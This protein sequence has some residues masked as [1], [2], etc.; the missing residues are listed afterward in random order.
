MTD[1]PK[2]GFLQRLA[3]LAIDYVILQIAGEAITYPL[4]KKFGMKTD[5]VLDQILSGAIDLK[6]IMVFLLV[7]T[8]LLTILWGFYFTYFVGSTGQTL[9]KK[10]LGIRVIRADEKPMDYKTAFNRFI[11]Y[12]VSASVLFLGFAWALFDANKQAWHDK[13]AHTY[14]VKQTTTL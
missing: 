9:G 12:T 10:A 5:E 11:G 8:T 2:A 4:E 13:T 6:Q 7:Y 1:F 14:V 3:A